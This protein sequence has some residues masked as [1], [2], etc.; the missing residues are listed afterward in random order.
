MSE[1]AKASDHIE[2]CNIEQ[3]ER[4]NR[5]DADY[6]ASLNPKTLYIRQDL[7]PNNESYVAPDVEGQSLQEIYDAIKVMVK[8]KTGRAMQE[9][10]VE[11]TDKKGRKKMRNGSSPLRESVVNIKPD[12]TMEDLR[13]YVERVQERW[14]VRAIQIHIHR[15]E[16]HYKDPE[17]PETWMPNLH[18]HIIWDWMNHETG[19]SC[20]LSKQDMSELQDMAAE[21]LEMERGKRKEE[22]GAEHLTR[23]DFIIQNQEK[24][25]QAIQGEIEEKKTELQEQKEEIT[26]LSH[27]SLLD[28][29]LHSGISPAVRKAIEDEKIA[30]QEELRKATTAVDENGNPYIWTS[31]SKKDQTVTW[32]ELAKFRE[33]EKKKA[34][35]QAKADKEAALAKAKADK[36]A[37]VAKVKADAKAELD[38]EIAE[39]NKLYGN[40]KSLT[41]KLSKS[42]ES[43][44]QLL[45]LLKG[46]KVFMFERCGQ[47][48]REV[49]QM[50]LDQ[51]KAGIKHFAKEMK[52]LFLQAM[53]NENTIEGCKSYVN[54]AFWY[55]E[56]IAK[57]VTDWKGDNATINSLQDDANRIADGTWDTYHQKRDQLFNVAVNA[58]VEMG[59][60]SYQRHLN[61]KQAEA[62][63]AFIDFDG[64]DRKQLCN[65]IWDHAKGN[66]D[67]YWRDGTHDALE[68][69]RTKDLYSNGYGGGRGI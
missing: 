67:R 49:V 33:K 24:K 21:T 9:R 58:L 51:W 35:I 54:D 18:A 56:L 36:E 50:I 68:E 64:G 69:L 12:T 46:I 53:S 34:E 6:I 48:F 65:E 45:D 38:A 19:K 7:S 10:M 43:Y 32:E 55:A 59:N 1:I 52:D 29:L 61:Q 3:S 63:E 60:C 40:I 11:V 31:G 26:K 16:G 2:P 4:H 41:E 66:V 44:K 17:N 42:E 27:S 13:K 20:K 23:T 8:Q 62:I 37:A 5:R 28:K 30:H 25:L 47:K 22:T 15:D 57:T 39:K 14:G